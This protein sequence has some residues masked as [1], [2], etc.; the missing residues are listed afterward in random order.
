MEAESQRTL[1]V[2][3]YPQNTTDCYLYKINPQLLIHCVY[4]KT[5]PLSMLKNFQN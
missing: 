1:Q 5:A 3:N 2:S 4:E